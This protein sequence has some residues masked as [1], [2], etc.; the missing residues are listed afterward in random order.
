LRAD[1]D[2]FVES[3]QAGPGQSVEPGDAVLSLTNPALLARLE[4]QALRVAALETSLYQAI[5]EQSALPGDARAGDARAELAA[6]QAELQRLNER[7]AALTIRAH[8]AGRVALAQAADL[9]GRYLRR[10]ALVGQVLTGVP[11]TVRVAFPEAEAAELQRRLAGVSVRL[12]ASSGVARDATLLRDSVGAV[13]QLPSAALSARHGGDVPTDPRDADDLR[14]TEPVV[15]V[16]VRLGASAGVSDERIGERAWVRLDSGLSPLA[17]QW[18][19][20]IR[21]Q[22]LR[23]F[24][25]QV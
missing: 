3:V 23:R 18:A 4:R 6:A 22:V 17:L 12:A 11:P 1:E 14:P 21:R 5:P 7:V 8:A 13:M 25:P 16:D 20:A 10:G 2:G 15:L 24:N 9:R 19:R